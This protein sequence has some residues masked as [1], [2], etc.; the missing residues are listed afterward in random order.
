[1]DLDFSGLK[2]VECGGGGRETE[3]PTD[4][5]GRVERT[6]G[7]DMSRIDRERSMLEKVDG[8]AKDMSV[9]KRKHFVELKHV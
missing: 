7:S 3:S 2:S 1:M 8:G 4:R 9:P 5:E 6:R